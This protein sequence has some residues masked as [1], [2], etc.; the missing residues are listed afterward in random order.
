[1]DHMRK[2]A[3][4][5]SLAGLLLSAILLWPG[6]LQG[7]FAISLDV[8]LVSVDVSVLDSG[9]RPVTN[10]NR[11]DFL[12]FENGTPQEIQTFGSADAPYDLVLLFD[13][14]ESTSRE[15]PLLDAATAGFSQYRRPQDRTL[16]AAFGERVQI[17]RNWNSQRDRR[18]DRISVCG[19]TRFYDALSWA[20]QRLNGIDNRKGVV[21]LT[22][23]VDSSIP[24]RMVDIGGRQVGAFIDSETD[25]TFQGALRRVRNSRIPFYFVAVGTD[26]NPGYEI[27]PH[28]S[29]VV[30]S[31]LRQM[32][33]RI[34]QLA[35]ASGGRVVFPNR[36]EDVIPMYEQI[37]RELG[38]SYSLG[39]VSSNRAADGKRRKI[40]VRLKPQ[41]LK[42]KQSRDG[43][44]LR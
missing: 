31:N 8:A 37:G 18:L 35:E 25:R 13:C 39:Y 16:I 7:Q 36:P 34:E 26:L 6:L 1:M 28:L 14:S 9:G 2:G 20:I 43:Y 42:L 38:T 30:T 4:A 19:G 5:C 17:I 24:T 15:W 21:M 3:S 41:G 23:G 33:S 10:L 40:E 22:D 32:R 44:T 29:N 27:P 12:V 11:N